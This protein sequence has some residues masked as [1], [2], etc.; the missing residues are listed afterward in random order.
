[1]AYVDL[2]RNLLSVV[3]LSKGAVSVVIGTGIAGFG[4]LRKSGDLMIS[5]YFCS[6]CTVVSQ[7][8]ALWEGR[9]GSWL[10]YFVKEKKIF[11]F[12]SLTPDFE[13]C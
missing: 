4:T 10:H 8:K 2:P 13:S 7:T 11:F 6:E 12:K 1:M 3:M 9:P 5:L